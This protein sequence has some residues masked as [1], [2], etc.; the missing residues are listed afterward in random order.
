MS[1]SSKKLF[2]TDAL[3]QRRVRAKYLGYEDFLCK[4][5]VH[6]LKDRLLEIDRDFERRIMIGPFAEHWQRHMEILNFEVGMDAEKLNF[7]YQYDYILHCLCLHWSNDPLGKLIQLR[8]GLKPEGLLMGYVFGGDTLNE[9]RISFSKAEIESDSSL[10]LR[11]APMMELKSFGNLLVKAG[12]KNIVVDLISQKIQYSSLNRLFT[13]LRRM[14]ETNV[15]NSRKKKFLTKKTFNFMME[16]YKKDFV[17]S[18]G[19]FKVTFDIFCFTGWK[20]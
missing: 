17:Q 15:I 19:T 14:G 11:V 20:S 18:D 4:L 6:D 8:M 9:L 3:F 2:D 13:D 16:N 5:L 7:L 10:S 1:K 12:F